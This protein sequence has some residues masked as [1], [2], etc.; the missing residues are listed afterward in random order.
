MIHILKQK[1]TYIQPFRKALLRKIKH[2]FHFQAEFT[3]YLI[4]FKR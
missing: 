2:W 1:K 4:Y 3:I